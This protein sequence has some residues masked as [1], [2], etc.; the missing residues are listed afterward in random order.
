[1]KILIVDPVGSKPYDNY[2]LIAEPLGGSEATVVRLANAFAAKG[3]NV[4]VTQH[5]R[6]D[7]VTKQGVEYTPF[8]KNED[9][10][11]THVIVQRAP[12]VLYTARKQY[13]NAKLYLHCHD[14]FGGEAWFKGFQ[15]MVD[16][17]TIPIVVSDFHKTQM[18]DVMRSLKFEGS[19]PCRRIYNPID[20][21]LRP[22]NMKVDPN[23]LLFFS[24]PHKGLEHTLKVFKQFK[25]FDELKGMKL[26]V[27]NPG[28]FKDYELDGIDSV[29]NLGPLPHPNLIK[30]LRSSFAALHLNSVFPETMGI[31]N[32]EANAVGTPFLSSKLGAT[33]ECADHPAEL[34][35]VNDEK[36]VIDRMIQWVRLGRPKVRGTPHFRMQRIMREWVELLNL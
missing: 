31:A 15:A 3:H 35:D 10:K 6:T 33:P 25:N 16:T 18:Y 30:E 27:A 28:Y 13:P 22:D 12:L 11:A 20:E 8:G 23:K 2:T 24:S 4:R 19:I 5:N 9:F 17:Q 32:A 7:S 14:L 1:M 36:A 26:Y 21:D 34:I 29:V